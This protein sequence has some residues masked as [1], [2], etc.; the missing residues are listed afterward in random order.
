MVQPYGIETNI[1]DNLALQA[2]AQVKTRHYAIV[3]CGDKVTMQQLHSRLYENMYKVTGDSKQKLYIFPTIYA[4]VHY[5]ESVLCG[6]GD[7]LVPKTV[8]DNCKQIADKVASKY[9]GAE[10]IK[11][12]HIHIFFCRG[13]SIDEQ[14][15]G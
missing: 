5:F 2:L 12:P 9:F 4:A 1:I 14:T 15:T 7:G 6:A 13:S 8:Y 11:F 10:G 3:D